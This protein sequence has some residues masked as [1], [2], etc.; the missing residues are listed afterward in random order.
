MSCSPLQADVHGMYGGGRKVSIGAN[1]ATAK[2]NAMKRRKK[3]TPC[4]QHVG[5]RRRGLASGSAGLRL[6]VVGLV[7]L[8]LLMAMP[9][10]A[11]AQQEAAKHP[12][13]KH[14]LD[15]AVYKGKQE[16]KVT[17]LVDGDIDP[18]IFPF[19][20][21]KN[22]MVVVDIPGTTMR[23]KKNTIPV[24]SARIK[25]VR[26]AQHSKP[27]KVR[28]VLDLLNGVAYDVIKP[29]LHLGDPENPEGTPTKLVVTVRKAK[30]KSQ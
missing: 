12:P 2:D 10:C 30:G 22:P 29:E 21:T 8:I 24:D 28:V 13:A 4:S 20:G 15:V 25:K 18:N 14:V 1:A 17:I 5:L 6:C 26:M 9:I 7:S 16:D 27:K 19:Q 11:Q 23:T 3:R